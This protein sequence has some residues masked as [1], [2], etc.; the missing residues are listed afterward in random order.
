MSQ[1]A[2]MFYQ[3]YTHVHV[4]IPNQRA[5][6]ALSKFMCKQFTCACCGLLFDYW[7][8]H[9]LCNR[10]PVFFFWPGT[11]FVFCLQKQ[12]KFLDIPFSFLAQNLDDF[13]LFLQENWKKNLT[14]KF[15][16]HYPVYN[17]KLIITCNY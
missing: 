16:K 17:Y 4:F 6:G 9:E 11:S 14:S 15:L 10:V 8:N 12:G 1:L 7:S 3:S 5:L 13:F 2:F